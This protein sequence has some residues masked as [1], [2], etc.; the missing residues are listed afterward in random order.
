[1]KTSNALIFTSLLAVVVLFNA[2]CSRQSSVQEQVIPPSPDNQL[3][4]SQNAFENLS[5]GT[6]E[7]QP[8][9]IRHRVRLQGELKIDEHRLAMIP[10][11]LT[12]I[13]ENLVVDVRSEVNTGQTL[14]SLSSR[15]LADRIM[16][17]VETERRFQASIVDLN[18]EKLLL[19][20]QVSTEEKFLKV[21]RAY[22]SALNEHS[23]ALQ[24]LR[25]LG[26]EETQ[27]HAYMDRPD[28]KDMTH[29]FVTSP[30][31]G[32]VLERYVSLGDAVEE[33]DAL[34]KVADLSELWL[35]FQLPM[36]YRSA[37]EMGMKVHFG[38]QSMGLE[39]V[40]EIT[41]IENVIDSQSRT[42]NVRAKVSNTDR[43]WMPGM[44]ARVAFHGLGTQVAKAVPQEAVQ[45]IDGRSVVFTE[46]EPNIFVPQTV[47]VGNKDA[48]FVE[49]LD[50]P[51]NGTVVV[52]TNCYLLKQAWEDKE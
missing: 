1:M 4:L 39:G 44:P 7:I 27:L 28:L 16:G 46:K 30:I 48:E 14:I 15:D 10:S 5:L 50:G 37:I 52:S 26:Y 13:V 21:E 49:L 47:T 41:L 42:I 24:R 51:P 19:E 36:R 3:E 33:G 43:K 25:L 38:N 32:E 9:E 18:R 34:F 11:R 29:Y 35:T 20:K 31:D 12:G 8:E 45:I 23:V 17:Y 2:S 6:S 22:H 40:A